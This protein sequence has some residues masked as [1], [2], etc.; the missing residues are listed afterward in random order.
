[1]ILL[2]ASDDWVVN[3]TH[4]KNHVIYISFAANDISSNH[5]H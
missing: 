3:E 5:K 2:F 1:M 4:K